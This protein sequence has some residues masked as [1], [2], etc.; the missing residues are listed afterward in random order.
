MTFVTFGSEIYA[1]DPGL[2]Q[3]VS[4]VLGAGRDQPPWFRS[5]LVPRTR[6]APGHRGLGIGLPWRGRA[7]AR[8]GT[9][10]GLAPAHCPR[11][12]PLAQ[13]SRPLFPD[14]RAP[15]ESPAN[16]SELHRTVRGRMTR[17]QPNG[18][19]SAATRE[20]RSELKA[21]RQRAASANLLAIRGG[22]P[23]WST[24]SGSGSVSVGGWQIW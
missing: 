6:R 1:P 22:W 23:A 19:G 21:T 18:L 14:G 3:P 5:D 11:G 24:T 10:H 7:P 12:C 17:G 20:S 2:D 9:H 4:D 13:P 8:L 16:G 15:S